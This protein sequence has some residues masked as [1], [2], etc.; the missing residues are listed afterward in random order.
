MIGKKRKWIICIILLCILIGVAVSFTVRKLSDRV[1]ENP[2]TQDDFLKTDGQKIVNQKGE[3]VYL[4]GTNLGGWLLQEYWMCPVK[5]SDSV[6]QWRNEETLDV[7][8]ER[9]GEEKAQQLIEEYQNN[10]ITEQD[11]RTI[12]K[13]GC[14]VVRVPFWYRNFMK[15]ADG[16]WLTEKLDDNPG[17]QKLDWLI[18]TC[19][20]YGVYVILDMHGCP[21]GQNAG[22][23]TGGRTCE[24]YTNEHYQDV[25]EELWVTIAERY[26]NNPAVAAYDIMNEA[27]EWDGDVASDPRNKV[28]D[29]MLKA[30]RE[31]DS[32]HIITIEGIWNFGVL[33]DPNE[34]GWENVVYQEHQYNV[35]DENAAEKLV[36]DWAAYR[37][38]HNVPVYL[39][40]F[41]Y[42]PFADACEKYNIPYTTWTYKGTIKLDEDWYMYYKYVEAA[43]VTR[44]SY[45][46]I[47][48]KWGSVLHTDDFEE[49]T[50]VTDIFR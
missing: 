29:R 34:I 9:F 22:H 41:S 14:N 17:I 13:A 5:G 32:D 42:M 43:D 6:A 23:T 49:V 19:Q 8:E 1:A 45:D 11:I 28:Y 10:W 3:E 31:V 37:E 36:A 27:Q 18:E 24:L 44:D 48:E 20:K 40:E 46:Q 4:K 25:M 2:M 30:I 47:K 39:G 16:T 33:P 35:K 26:K 7:L 50:K 15:D 12:A 38:Q 21:G